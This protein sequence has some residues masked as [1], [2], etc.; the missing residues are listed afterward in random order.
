MAAT[1]LGVDFTSAPSRR[2]PIVVARGGL[3]GSTLGIAAVDHLVDFQAF[4]V[5]LNVQGPWIA[6]FDLPFGLPRELLTIMRWPVCWRDMVA[7]MATIGKADFK[8]ALNSVRESRPMGARYIP[9]AGDAAAGASSPMKLVNP[10]VGLM[11]FEGASRIA[12][13]GVSVIPCAPNE[14]A[15]VAIEG[16]P[17][18]LARQITR[19]SYKKDGPEGRTPSRRR[20][21]E[22]IVVALLNGHPAMGGL[23]V[24]LPEPLRALCISDGNGDAL[25]SVV[26][27]V[28]AARS[29]IAF[30]QGD[31]M[32]GIPPDADSL[33]GWIA[34]VSGS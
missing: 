26:C 10:P 1:V 14:D 17:G 11:F 5:L 4:D 34:T 33:E 32:Y 9:R 3:V 6:A 27:A 7:H 15:R 21:R 22:I 16:Y 12:K 25:D 30:Q 8:H 13:S 19:E 2:K 31:P 20:S 29:L 23:T 18:F 28:Q 24:K